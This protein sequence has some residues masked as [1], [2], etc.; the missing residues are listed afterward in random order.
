MRSVLFIIVACLCGLVACRNHNQNNS[1]PEPPVPAADQVVFE[2][3]FEGVDPLNHE[4]KRTD[5]CVQV[6]AISLDGWPIYFLASS[7]D[8]SCYDKTKFES[9][10]MIGQRFQRVKVDGKEW[11][12]EI[13]PMPDPDTSPPSDKN[14]ITQHPTTSE[15]SEP[16]FKPS[17]A[18]RKE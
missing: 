6:T 12:Y 17:S 18:E 9:R 1:Q 15:T 13:R 10:L 2:G 3:Y 16:I 8:S 4:A 14:S 5:G 11:S 7:P